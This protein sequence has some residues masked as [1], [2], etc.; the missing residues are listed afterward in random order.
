MKIFK[1]CIKYFFEKI[2]EISKADIT[3]ISGYGELNDECKTQYTTMQEFLINTFSNENEGY[4]YN[5]KEMF[6]TTVLDKET[7][8]HYYKKMEEKN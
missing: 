4:W 5:W 2:L 6:E 1:R 7:F 3:T 8:Y